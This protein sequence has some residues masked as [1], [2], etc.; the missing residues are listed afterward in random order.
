MKIAALESK[1]V[2]FHRELWIGNANITTKSRFRSFADC[3]I[4]VVKRAP[5]TTKSGLKSDFPDEQLIAYSSVQSDSVLKTSSSV[6]FV[7]ALTR[8]YRP[9]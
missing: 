9:Y 5:I 8:L 4:L 6:A 2:Q 3:P 7:Q 1:I